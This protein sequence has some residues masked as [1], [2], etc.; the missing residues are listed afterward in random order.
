MMTYT[1]SF[2]LDA[3]KW[4]RGFQTVHQVTPC[5]E[6]LLWRLCIQ[7]ICEAIRRYWVRRYRLLEAKFWGG[8][9][10][11]KA[12]NKEDQPGGNCIMEIFVIGAVY[13]ILWW[14]TLSGSETEGSRITQGRHK[15]CMEKFSRKT[16]RE[17]PSF[18]T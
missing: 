10:L 11:S 16:W 18:F 4:N 14:L 9:Q 2:C 1:D 17:D 3:K 13:K 5:S 6:V 12:W 15:E 7:R 8:Q